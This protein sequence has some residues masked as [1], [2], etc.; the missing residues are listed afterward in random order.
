M[1]VIKLSIHETYEIFC[2]FLALLINLQ[3]DI[4][5]SVFFC[6]TILHFM[7]S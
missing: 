4:F 1:V 3:S 2:V 6:A 7:A 5:C